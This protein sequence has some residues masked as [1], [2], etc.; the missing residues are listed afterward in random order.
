M[1]T[2]VRSIRVTLKTTIAHF[3]GGTA[4][5]HI[6]IVADID[7]AACFDA[8]GETT[9]LL[10][11]RLNAQQHTIKD[12]QTWDLYSIYTSSSSHNPVT[13]WKLKSCD[14]VRQHVLP[15]LLPDPTTN[16]T[17]S[18]GVAVLC[19]ARDDTSAMG[20]I[21]QLNSF[22]VH[23]NDIMIQTA[24][25]ENGES[26]RLDPKHIAADFVRFVKSKN[27]I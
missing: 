14:I 23:V 17:C 10:A 27:V 26:I 20:W 5:R 6:L 8:L 12:N 13:M 9:K 19:I 18:T 24:L 15:H 7:D 25:S 3:K 21:A 11:R 2:A 4:L 1:S 16:S 22:N